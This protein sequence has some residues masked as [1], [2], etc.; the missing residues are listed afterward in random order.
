VEQAARGED[1]Y[2]VM[3]VCLEMRSRINLLKPTDYVMQ[4]QV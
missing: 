4:Q 1:D 3:V 2:C